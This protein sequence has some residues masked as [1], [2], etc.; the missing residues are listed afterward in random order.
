MVSVARLT[1]HHESALSE[2]S[3]DA[4]LASRDVVADLLQQIA[5]GQHHAFTQLYN[6]TSARLLTLATRIVGQPSLGEDA[7]QEA[8]VRVWNYADRFDPAKGSGLS[9]LVTI[10]RNRALTSKA[11]LRARPIADDGNAIVERAEDSLDAWENLSNR[12]TLRRIRSCLARLTDN[13]RRSI[14]LTYFEGL[15]HSE[16]AGRLD[17]PVGTAKSWVRRGLAQLGTCLHGQPVG[18]WREMVAAEY[19]VGSLQGP[20]RA[21]FERKREFDATYCTPAFAWEAAFSELIV[22]LAGMDDAARRVWTKLSASLFE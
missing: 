12:E 15:T 2:S 16:L 8:F 14:L 1:K 19:V 9:W 10:V 11:A 4:S 5:R 17:V 20:A 21:A 13:H 22:D 18:D 3:S 6:T 7:V